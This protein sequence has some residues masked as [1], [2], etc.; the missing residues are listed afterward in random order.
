MLI[1]SGELSTLNFQIPDTV[2][3]EF[4]D[5]T[6]R[7]VVDGPLVLLGDLSENLLLA[8]WI[9]EGLA[10]LGLYHHD[11]LHDARSLVEDAY[12]FLVDL[13]YPVSELFYPCLC[14]RTLHKGLILSRK[15]LLYSSVV[16]RFPLSVACS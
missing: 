6:H 4:E 15:P 5:L 7:R 12:E 13:V 11:L 10:R 16:Q 8:L 2:Q 1:L 3:D 9:E 14:I